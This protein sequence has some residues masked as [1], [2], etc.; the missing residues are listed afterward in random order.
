MVTWWQGYGSKT[1][2]NTFFVKL[3]VIT[4]SISS[5]KATSLNHC[6]TGISGTQHLDTPLTDRQNVALNQWMFQNGYKKGTWGFYARWNRHQVRVTPFLLRGISNISKMSGSLRIDMQ[7]S[8]L[9]FRPTSG[10]SALIGIREKL[11]WGRGVTPAAYLRKSS[12]L[13]SF[14]ERR[15]LV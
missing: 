1:K 10:N 11:P 2:I 3:I 13:R 9:R 15:S 8:Y 4:T 5:F 7:S 6:K 14:S 12:A